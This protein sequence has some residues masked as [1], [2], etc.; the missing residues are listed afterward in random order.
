MRRF[1]TVLAI[2]MS[3]VGLT[4]AQSD[5]LVAAREAFQSGDYQRAVELLN[6]VAMQGRDG[7]FYINLATAQRQIGDVPG[8]LISLLRAQQVLPRD[9]EIA[10]TLVRV[11]AQLGVLN[12]ADHEDPLLQI[13]TITNAVMTFS[14]LAWLSFALWVA[15]WLLLLLRLLGRRQL[16]W[17]NPA[18]VTLWPVCIAVLVLFASRAYVSNQ[19]PLAVAVVQSMVYSGPDVTYPTI[20]LLPAG[21]EVRSTASNNEWTQYL[22]PDGSRGWV[23]TG[24]L[25]FIE[26]DR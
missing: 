9:S 26:W 2:V 7:A 20:G 15:S 22:A 21:Q 14:E 5:P 10:E 6:S 11:R 3:L 12:D 1:L 16:T 4:A 19:R 23:E 17:L 13:G 8:A 25:S 18:I 24:N